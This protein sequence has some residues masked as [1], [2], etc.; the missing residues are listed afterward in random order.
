MAAY[1]ALM[2][3]ILCVCVCAYS[4]AC[5]SLRHIR[6]RPADDLRSTCKN[7]TVLRNNCTILLLHNNIINHTNIIIL[8]VLIIVLIKIDTIINVE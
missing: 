6:V 2:P 3:M 5:K 4:S 8:A 1:M 7:A